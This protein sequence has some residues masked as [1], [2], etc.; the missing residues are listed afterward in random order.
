MSVGFVDLFQCVVDGAAGMWGKPVHVVGYCRQ[1]R[2]HNLQVFIENLGR[3]RKLSIHAEQGRLLSAE[4]SN[5]FAKR[6]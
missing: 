5:F 4:V 1:R 3:Q 6:F 2:A